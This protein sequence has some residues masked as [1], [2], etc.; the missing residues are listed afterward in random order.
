MKYIYLI[1]IKNNKFEKI[2]NI[3]IINNLYFLSHRLPTNEEIKKNKDALDF[4]KKN[5]IEELKKNICNSSDVI[6][7]FNIYHTNLYLIKKE[8]IYFRVNY[9]SY[10]FL[11]KSIIDFI[12][13]KYNKFIN[14]I[15]KYDEVIKRKIKKLDLILKFIKQLDMEELEKLYFKYY[16]TYSPNTT[17]IINCKKPSFIN[18]FSHLK[19]YYSRNELINL[20]KNMN[21]KLE[22]NINNPDNID[23]LCK[24]VTDNDIN[25]NI[26]LSHQT[27]VIKNDFTSLIKYYTIQGSFYINQYM[28]N[29]TNYKTKNIFL[30]KNIKFIW[31]GILNSPSFDKDYYIYRFI[32]TDYF[33]KNLEIGDIY[34]EE[35]FLS[36]TRD[37]F[38]RPTDFDFGTI[39]IKI[40][41]PKNI[42]GVALCIETLSHFP[43]EQEII[44]P[45]K[46]NF[47]LISRNKNL[48]YYHTNP[49][50]NEKIKTKYEFEW[51]K[52][53][54]I[55]FNK[56]KEI[57]EKNNVS[58]DF[59]KIPKINTFSLEEKIKIFTNKYLNS[60]N[61]FNVDIGNKQ[62]YLI[63]EWFDSSNVYK[64][65][66]ALETTNGYSIYTIYEKN[67]LFMIELAEIGDEIKMSVNYYLR[68]T[69]IMRKDIIKEVDFITFL[70]KIAYFFNISNIIIYSD[71]ISCDDFYLKNN[72]KQRSIS[73]NLNDNNK[74]NNFDEITT[75]VYYGSY[76]SYD[77]NKYLV[78]NKKRFINKN[79]NKI[80]IRELFNYSE[81]D[82]L[83][84]I[85]PDT[86]LN[87]KDNDE[88]YQIYHRNY[89]KTNKNN[90]LSDFYLWIIKNYCYLTNILINKMKRIFIINNPFENLFY[91]IN[92]Y[93]YLYNKKLIN[94]I[95]SISNEINNNNIKLIYNGDQNNFVR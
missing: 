30:E 43:D 22:G 59:L 4:Y 29:L 32:K 18:V 78:E 71:F 74:E 90:N 47:K 81:L 1:N 33:I 11:S 24:L 37:P 62:F 3:N 2:K 31:N 21:L 6:P 35:G 40:K 69:N 53:D 58:I 76:Y 54:V 77:I 75:K 66:Y 88:L 82:K 93:I 9:N 8:N 16:Y 45:P 87:K 72:S 60:M 95:P 83:K 19:P 23:E 49:V 89:S 70:C 20:S 91:S 7:L 36:T 86:I 84:K 27:H 44:F 68:Y 64:K 57:L 5:S 55:S 26:L 48:K 17:D 67:I 46:S 79:F 12:K 25:S 73:S 52:N 10:R 28:R 41:I 56:N 65:F 92:P 42:K 63:G 13:E 15:D 50:F 38:Y 51:I 94:Y 85:K 14:S 34:V 61:G 39:L 80:E